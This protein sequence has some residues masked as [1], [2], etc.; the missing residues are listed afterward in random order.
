MHACPSFFLEYCTHGRENDGAYAQ[1]LDSPSDTFHLM[2]PR[3]PTPQTG[4]ILALGTA[5]T[6]EGGS[7][8]VVY[9]STAA[10]HICNPTEAMSE[11][12]DHRGPT[13]NPSSVPV[14]LI[15]PIR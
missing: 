10:I 9:T 12:T 5:D 7:D 3:D 14:H 2:V 11:N 4:K 1:P 15:P 13:V 8:T 6:R